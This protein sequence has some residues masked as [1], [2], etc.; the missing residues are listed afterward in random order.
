MKINDL[1][2]LEDLIQLVKNYKLDFIEVDNI[3]I[4]K[5]RHEEIIAQS[6]KKS[7]PTDFWINPFG[8]DDEQRSFDGVRR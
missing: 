7:A 3:K 8:V 1:K 5:S 4:T 2:E 6:E